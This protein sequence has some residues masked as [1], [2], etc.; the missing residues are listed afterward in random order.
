MEF[1]ALGDVY[2]GSIRLADLRTAKV[3]DQPLNYT[4]FVVCAFEYAEPVIVAYDAALGQLPIDRLRRKLRQS[5]KHGDIVHESQGTF[6]DEAE[7]K[8]MALYFRSVHN[9]R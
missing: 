1:S 9:G 4:L 2:G 7:M 8:A 3:P 5:V 6:R